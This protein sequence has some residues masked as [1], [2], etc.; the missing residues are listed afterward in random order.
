MR[1]ITIPGIIVLSAVFF[2][3]FGNFAFFKNVIEVYPV[4]LK[5]IGFLA[6]LMLVLTCIMVILLTWC[7]QNIPLNPFWFSPL[8]GRRSPGTL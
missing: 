4:S 8:W 5:N 6:S 3:L 1:R 2:V 7:R